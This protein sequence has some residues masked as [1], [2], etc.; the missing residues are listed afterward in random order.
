MEFM[1]TA[2]I[3]FVL[4]IIVG[5]M[6]MIGI[7]MGYSFTILSEEELYADVDPDVKDD[8]KLIINFLYRIIPT[9]RLGEWIARKINE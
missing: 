9:T 6:I 1:I 5:L 4:G 3:W 7:V 2:L 8:V